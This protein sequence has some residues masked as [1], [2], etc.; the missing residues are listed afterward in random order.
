MRNRTSAAIFALILG[1]IGA[2]KFYLG[3]AGQGLLYLFFFWTFI[4]AFVGFIEGIMLL[5]MNDAEFNA[6]YNQGMVFAFAAPPPPPQN[7]VVSV[8][9][10]ATGG[11]SD[12]VTRLKDLHDLRTSGGLSDAEYE[13]EKQRLLASGAN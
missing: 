4:P 9:N 6:K 1:G 7:I 5:T 11:G 2:H 13:T 3:R 10:T 12:R 8:A